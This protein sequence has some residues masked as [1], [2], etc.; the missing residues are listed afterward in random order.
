[1][2]DEVRQSVVDQVM[3]TRKW[4]VETARLAERAGFRCEYCGLDFLQSP[5]NYKLFQVDHIVPESR[6]GSSQ[7]DNLAIACMQCNYC[8]KCSHDPR[9]EAGTNASREVLVQAAREFI[10]KQKASTEQELAVLRA[11]VG[12]PIVDP[13][14]HKMAQTTLSDTVQEPLKT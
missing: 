3:A 14:A 9:Q 10:A 5:E 1:M 8:F 6:G 2:Q 13:M 11:I 12:R 4:S 7:P